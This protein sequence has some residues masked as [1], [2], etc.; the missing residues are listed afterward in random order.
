MKK[1]KVFTKSQVALAVMLAALAGAVWLNMRYSAENAEAANN[2]SSKYLGSASFVNGETNEEQSVVTDPVNVYFNRL[3]A[4]RL[5]SREDA[6]AIIEEALED[7]ELSEDKK[8]TA[9]DTAAALALR[10]EKEAAVETLLKAK[11]FPSAVAVI[12]DEDIN[13]IVE[14]A[15]LGAAEVVQI[16][17]A[18]LSQTD[19]PASKIKIVTMS[20]EEIEKALK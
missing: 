15:G 8:K 20:K 11:G 19:F 18:A 9:L 6:C 7:T 5:K 16:Q 4:D 1:G 17:D 10:T 13:I 12:G 2:E 14:S 3:R